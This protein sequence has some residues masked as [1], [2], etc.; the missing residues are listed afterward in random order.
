MLA[1]QD[2]VEFH[3]AVFGRDGADGKPDHNVHIT[4]VLEAQFGFLVF[5][6]WPPSFRSFV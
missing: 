3:Q 1:G 2:E 5:T 4:F 6:V